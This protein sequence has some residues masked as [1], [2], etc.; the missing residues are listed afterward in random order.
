M[1][2]YFFDLHDGDVHTIDDFGI[3]F[4]RLEEARNYAVSLLPDMARE[5]LPNGPRRDF[6]CDI[7]AEGAQI[8]YRAVLKFREDR[9]DTQSS[10][11]RAC[12]KVTAVGGDRQ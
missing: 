5:E 3:E 6:I 4:D 10:E 12:D 1:P 11:Q 7:R 9:F 8:V 2:L